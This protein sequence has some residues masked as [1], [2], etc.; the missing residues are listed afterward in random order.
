MYVEDE[1]VIITSSQFTSFYDFVDGDLL[2][3][4]TIEYKNYLDSRLYDNNLYLVAKNAID[5]EMPEDENVYYTVGSRVRQKYD[6]YKINLDSNEIK[7]TAN[8]NAGNVVL[9]MSNEHI[10]LATL[11]H[12]VG[13]SG[14][15]SI[16]VTSIFDKELQPVGA[17]GLEGNVLNQFSMDEYNGYFR[18]VTSDLSKANCEINAL[19]IYSLE[20]LQKVGSINKNLG[21][22]KQTVRSVAFDKDTCHVVTYEVTDPLYEIDLSD[23]TNPKIVSIYKAPGYSSYL[24][25]F[26][27]E[28]K[29]YLFGLGYTDDSYIRKISIYEEK[30]DGTTQV[31]EDFLMS[32]VY[33]NNKDIDIF[34]DYAN[35]DSFSH[36]A[37]LVYNDGNDLYL[38]MKL[39]TNKYYIFKIDVDSNEVVSI[40]KTFEF[41]NSFND[42]RC[43]MIDGKLYITD[44]HRVVIKDFK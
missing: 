25:K 42:S 40:Y 27:I 9:Y 3:I 38:G 10:Y 35:Y 24:Q 34:L 4:N 43:Y 22:D 11:V 41:K 21:E 13:E 26:E 36:K 30:D 32:S 17:I 1:N 19:S 14:F 18:V 29:E 16:T 44:Y 5:S 20:T 31:G 8:L 39:E 37:L 12:Y 28:D 2:H 33:V 23:V 6:L 7:K 15:Y